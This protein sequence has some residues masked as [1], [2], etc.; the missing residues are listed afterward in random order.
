MR[1]SLVVVLAAVCC[2]QTKRD[3]RLCADVVAQLPASHDD[4]ELPLT[5]RARFELRQCPEGNIQVYGYSRNAA[6][7]TM[8]FD[9]ISDWPLQLVRVQNALLLISHGGS[10]NQVF[11]FEFKAGT[12]R[13]AL[14]G[15]SQADMPVRVEDGHLRVNVPEPDDNETPSRKWR[16]RWYTYPSSH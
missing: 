1:L 16:D 15:G 2:A 6:T 4:E 3:V 9:T 11:V 13:V 10:A 5:R 7:A 14:E 12:P 8:K